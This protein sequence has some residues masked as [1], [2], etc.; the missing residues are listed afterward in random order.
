MELILPDKKYYPSY[1]E[2]IREY[3]EHGVHTLSLIH[4]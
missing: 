4:I 2:A 3:R 1:L